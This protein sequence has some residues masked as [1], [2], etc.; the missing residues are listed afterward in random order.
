[1]VRGYLDYVLKGLGTAVSVN[2]FSGGLTFDL[3]NIMM[4]QILWEW[5]KGSIHIALLVLPNANH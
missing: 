1:M 5:S 4:Q 3:N 2:T